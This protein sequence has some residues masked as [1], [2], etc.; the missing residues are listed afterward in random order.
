LAGAFTE[1]VS[2]RR[3]RC[4]SDANALHLHLRDATAKGLPAISRNST[5]AA[6][7]RP[8]SIIASQGPITVRFRQVISRLLKGYDFVVKASGDYLE[9]SVLGASTPTRDFSASAPAA[10]AAC[11]DEGVAS[12]E[13]PATLVQV[14][15]AEAAISG[16]V[17][18]FGR[19]Q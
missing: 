2:E 16:N 15:A 19:Q 6:A 3:R 9:L 8:F 17:L 12:E 18:V 11:V 7:R 10:P 13:N 14:V 5:H 1:N 4:E